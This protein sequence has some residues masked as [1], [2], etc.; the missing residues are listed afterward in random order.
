MDFA[1]EGCCVIAMEL[2]ALKR[3]PPE[4]EGLIYQF[5]GSATG[6]LMKTFLEDPDTKEEFEEYGRI[7]CYLIP[8]LELGR[9]VKLCDSANAWYWKK[10]CMD[11]LKH[12][13]NSDF[14]YEVKR[15]KLLRWYRVDLNDAEDYEDHR[16]RID[17]IPDWD[18]LDHYFEVER[19]R[20]NIMDY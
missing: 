9:E 11:D 13:S 15:R 14:R 12:M 16:W 8:E 6:G 1:V 5:V 7:D 19:K 4:V 10:C 17:F 18:D 20:D 3:L 2:L